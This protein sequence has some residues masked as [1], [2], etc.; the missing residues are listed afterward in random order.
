MKNAR[1]R[2]EKH[3]TACECGRTCENLAESLLES[4]LVSLYWGMP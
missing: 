3:A 1:A 4:L 2:V